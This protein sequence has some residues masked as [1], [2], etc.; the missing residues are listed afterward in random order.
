[1]ERKA[2]ITTFDVLT[3]INV[4]YTVLPS[5]NIR[6]D[7]RRAGSITWIAFL[8]A[9]LCSTHVAKLDVQ[10]KKTSRGGSIVFIQVINSISHSKSIIISSAFRLLARPQCLQYPPCLLSPSIHVLSMRQ[11][12][13]TCHTLHS[14][15]PPQYRQSCNVHITQHLQLTSWSTYGW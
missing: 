11:I 15:P 3:S 1:M 10:Q 9:V 14:K 8:L 5:Y 12:P 4:E 7:I 13:F 6:G 2:R